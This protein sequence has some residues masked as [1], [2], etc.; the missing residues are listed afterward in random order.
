MP[1]YLEKRAQPLHDDAAITHPEKQPPGACEKTQGDASTEVC[2]VC[3]AI[4]VEAVFAKAKLR[5]NS[6]EIVRFDQSPIS[7]E[8]IS[9]QS[10]YSLCRFFYPT[11]SPSSV[12]L[13]YHLHNDSTTDVFEVPCLPLLEK[14]VALIAKTLSRLPTLQEVRIILEHSEAPNAL[15]ARLRQSQVDL[16]LIAGWL[17][18]C[19]TSHG[20][21]C[22]QSD[23]PVPQG[24][25]IIDCWA[26]ALVA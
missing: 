9:P 10:R 6:S 1:P 23:L 7:L 22:K 14:S 18:L 15:S 26:R 20:Q 21:P 11:R 19:R 12:G 16:S 3:R 24:W 5:L 2:S 25:R 8:H 13:I 17:E 4:D